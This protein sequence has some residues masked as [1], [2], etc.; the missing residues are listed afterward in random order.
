MPALTLGG[1]LITLIY[2]Y[3]ARQHAFNKMILVLFGISVGL[4]LLSMYTRTFWGISKL[5]AT[6]AW[7]FLCSAI[8]TLAFIAIY[9]VADIRKKA[10]WF[11]FIRPAGT[12]TLLCYLIPYFAYALVNVLGIHWPELMLTGLVG[13]LK[14]F[15]FALLCVVV[16]GIL[17]KNG[18]RL[19]L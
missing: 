5:R 8:T 11:S 18:I 14:S 12:D 6:P 3:F 2:E 16:T 7:L 10:Q 9:Y 15:V 17:S 1:V 13:L 4:I 19:K